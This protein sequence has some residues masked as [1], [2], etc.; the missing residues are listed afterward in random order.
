M[1]NWRKQEKSA[2]RDTHSAL[3]AWGGAAVAVNYASPRSDA[4]LE[5]AHLA[6]LNRPEEEELFAELDRDWYENEEK[7]EGKENEEADGWDELFGEEDV[8]EL[9]GRKGDSL[10]SIL[11]RGTIKTPGGFSGFPDGDP[12][13]QN[14]QSVPPMENYFDVAMHGTP[15]QVGFGSQKMNMSAR[16]LADIIR[17]SEGYHGQSI[18]LEDTQEGSAFTFTLKKAH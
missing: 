1:G 11:K 6:E 10:Q 13:N 5:Q 7:S 8:L 2:V 14:V 4:E 17:H 3:F 16:T 9:A 15:T 12:L 18:R